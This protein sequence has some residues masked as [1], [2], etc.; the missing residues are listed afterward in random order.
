MALRT[1]LKNDIKAIVDTLLTYDG[2]AGKTQEDAKEKFATDL[3]DAIVDAMKDTFN[4][5]IP[6]VNDGGAALKTAWSSHTT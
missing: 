4:Q 2:T 3:S 1:D 5:G 6:V